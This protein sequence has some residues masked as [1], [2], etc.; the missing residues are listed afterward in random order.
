MN[1][2]NYSSLPK[3]FGCYILCNKTEWARFWRK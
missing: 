3:R 1:F 2:S